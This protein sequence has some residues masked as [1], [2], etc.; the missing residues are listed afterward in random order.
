CF[1]HAHKTSSTAWYAA[2][3]ML[4]GL[5]P[6]FRPNMILLPI[7]VIGAYLFWPPRG[8]RRLVQCAAF[9]LAMIAMLM[10]WIIRNYRYTGTI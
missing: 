5:T 3:G 9:M 7:L 4:A 10:P 2:S 8:R 6:Q 1:V